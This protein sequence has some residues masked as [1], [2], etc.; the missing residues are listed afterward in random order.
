[1]SG[2]RASTRAA[3]LREAWEAERLVTC[4]DFPY[5]WRVRPGS[6]EQARMRQRR[7]LRR[8]VRRQMGR[9]KVSGVLA[10]G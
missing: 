7:R 1:M 9:Q 5:P 8:R 6:V 4:F 3:L 2:E 10:D